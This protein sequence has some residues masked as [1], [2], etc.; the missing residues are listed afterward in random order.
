MDT[1]TRGAFT[2]VEWQVALCDPI[3]QVTLRSSEMGFSF[4]DFNH[5]H[6][7]HGT[8]AEHCRERL[9]ADDGR[10]EFDTSIVASMEVNGIVYQ[11][12]LFAQPPNVVAARI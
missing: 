9:V 2:C 1:G 3:W 5:Q 10:A 12:V 4:S 11:G 6:V 7:K 8:F